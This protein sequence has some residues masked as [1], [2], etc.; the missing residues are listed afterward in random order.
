MANMSV[1]L[2]VCRGRRFPI[3]SDFSVT[4]DTGELSRVF[5]RVLNSVE[6]SVRRA[7]LI[8]IT[9]SVNLD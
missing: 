5:L 6:L 4:R 1:S 8:N 9:S 3:Q 2:K 7:L